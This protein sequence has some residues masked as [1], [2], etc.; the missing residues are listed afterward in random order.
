MV[1]RERFAAVVAHSLFGS[2]IVR[3]FDKVKPN[4]ASGLAAIDAVVLSDLLEV[5]R[6]KRERRRERR[7]ARRRKNGR[8]RR[9]GSTRAGG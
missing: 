6:R 5:I 9:G 8:R 7:R 4:D 2:H 1:R 3:S